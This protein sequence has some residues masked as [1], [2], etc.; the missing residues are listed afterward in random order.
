MRIDKFLKVSRILKRRTLAQEAC[1]KGKVIINGREAKPSSQ[2]KEGDTVAV[3]FAGGELKFKILAV[4]ET[5][6]KDEAASMYQIYGED[7]A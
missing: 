6:K 2:V 4:K 5:V 3:K 7:D 1:E